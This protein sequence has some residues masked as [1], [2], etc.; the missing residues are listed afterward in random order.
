MRS[1]TYNKIQPTFKISKKNPYEKRLIIRKIEFLQQ[2]SWN[3][4]PKINPSWL[5]PLDQKLILFSKNWS[6]KIPLGTV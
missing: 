4:L 2:K 3:R 5:I 6:Q 1:E